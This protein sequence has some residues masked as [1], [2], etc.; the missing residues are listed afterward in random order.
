[1]W[2]RI[3]KVSR[4]SGCTAI[5]RSGTINLKQLVSETKQ[6]K[7]KIRSQ[8]TTHFM[9]SSISNYVKAPIRSEPGTVKVERSIGSLSFNSCT[10]VSQVVGYVIG[11]KPSSKFIK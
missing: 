6:N 10:I 3:Y 5:F 1:M 11:D 2:N 8:R 7:Y 9:Y 4:S